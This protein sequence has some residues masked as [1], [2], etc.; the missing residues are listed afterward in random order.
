MTMKNVFLYLVTGL[1]YGYVMKYGGAYATTWSMIKYKKGP[2]RSSRTIK[3]LTIINA[4]IIILFMLAFQNVSGRAQPGFYKE[5]VMPSRDAR[6]SPSLIDLSKYYTAPLDN[7]WLV[8]IGVNLQQLPKG[9][10][11]FAGVKFDV[12]GIV[13][14]A[15]TELLSK[16]TL[17]D[18]EKAK[19][20]PR[21]VEGMP[22]KLKADKIHFLQASAWGAET[23]QKVGEYIVYYSDGSK[24]SIPLLYHQALIDWWVK[25]AADKP[26]NAEIAWQGSHT[27]NI[28]NLFKYTWTNPSPQITI[29]KIDFVSAMT[30]AAPFM[31]ALTCEPIAGN[32]IK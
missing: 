13:Q 12:R 25:T 16:S 27:K 32:D 4:P 6:T 7:D 29:D 2:M 10:Q 5:G 31:I 30:K 8:S 18:Q 28:A 20:Y 23:N 26:A 19:Q 9:I 1:V 3:G 17:S 11:T 15:S 14:L 24:Q 21:S 22:V